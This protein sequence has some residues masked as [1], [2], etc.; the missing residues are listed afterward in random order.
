MF[1]LWFFNNHTIQNM[2]I[3]EVYDWLMKNSLGKEIH[4]L[5]KLPIH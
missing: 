2:V 5:L 4:K 3:E 1:Y